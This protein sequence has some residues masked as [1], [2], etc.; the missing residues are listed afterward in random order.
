[1]LINCGDFIIETDIVRYIGPDIRPKILLENIE[2][3]LTHILL[4]NSS[5]GYT[6]LLTEKQYDY[7]K[8]QL[9]DTGEI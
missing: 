9:I 8:Q 4:V 5:P 1:M 6:I 7:I 2:D 3:N